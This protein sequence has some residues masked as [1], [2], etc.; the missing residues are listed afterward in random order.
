[1]TLRSSNSAQFDYLRGY[2]DEFES[3]LHSPSFDD[4]ENGYASY[5]DVPSFIDMHLFVETFKEID[6]YRISTYFSKDRGGKI[7]A[8]PVWDYNLALGNA[9]YLAGE[10]PTGWYYTQ[11]SGTNYYWYQRM[12]QD[13]EFDLAYWDR[14]WELRRGLFGTPSMMA[15]I[16]RLDDEL[17][18]AGGTPNAVTRNFDRWG[19]LG[20]YVWPNAAGYGSR[21]SHQAEVDWM[22][23]WLTQRLAWIETQSRGTDGLSRP[24]TFNQYGGEV[25]G[26]F[27]LTMSDPNGWGGASI[28]Y[29][30]DGSDPRV[31]GNSAGLDTAFVDDGAA[32]QALVPS[33]A[34]GGSSLS[35]GDWTGAAAPPNVGNWTPGTLGVGY[36]RSSN[37][38]YDPLINLD[39]EGQ[40]YGNNRSCFIRIPFAVDSQSQIDGLSQLTLR[41]RYDDGFVAYLNGIEIARPDAPAQA[42]FDSGA[43]GGHS[44]DD[45]GDV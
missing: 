18:G 4:P 44:D 39:F 3:A 19:I 29:T 32:C 5:I 43:T 21:L 27:D 23:D 10:I 6:G 2:V 45:A 16:D 42:N 17:D 26:G 20:S 33:V 9:D 15:L 35:V 37:N 7:H 22:K 14:F 41:M 13:V 34:N 11:T 30:T 25:A 40:L 38:R 24:P 12:F 1:M 28:V 36:E 31:A 8:L